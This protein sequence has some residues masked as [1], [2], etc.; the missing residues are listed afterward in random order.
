MKFFDLQT[1]TTVLAITKSNMQF[2]YIGGNKIITRNLGI[3]I[4]LNVK[5][6]LLA[7]MIDEVLAL[8]EPHCEKT[9]TF[10][11]FTVDL[12]KSGPMFHISFKNRMGEIIFVNTE[13]NLKSLQQFLRE[14]CSS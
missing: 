14:N 1:Y 11:T 12:Y 7:A 10:Q 5:P 6:Q 2:L 13:E 8:A 3:T 4:C 9:Q